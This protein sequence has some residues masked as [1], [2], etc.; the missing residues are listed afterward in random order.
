MQTGL[1]HKIF[2]TNIFVFDD[3]LDE[4]LANHIKRY[5]EGPFKKLGKTKSF[6]R[7]TRS[8]NDNWQTEPNLHTHNLFKPFVD[9]I[10]E[11]N[12]EILKILDY[13]IEDIKISDMWANILRPGES[14]SVHT[15]SNN[16][17]GGVYYLQS[18]EVANIMFND[19]RPASDVILPRIKKIGKD[20]SSV[21]GYVSTQNRAI[22]FPAWLQHW[23]PVNKST[24]N[25]IS[26]AWNIQL[27]GQVGEH[28]EFQSAEF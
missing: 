22:I 21:V 1:H 27:K 7:H 5:I 14:H 17:L 23:V 28:H 26:I 25:R 8:Y 11:T 16:F 20:N 13:S 6:N 12:E 9:K 18:D 10:I 4:E 3:F 2:A 19:P 24:N 15:H